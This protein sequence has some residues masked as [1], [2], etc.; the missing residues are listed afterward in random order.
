MCVEEGGD[1]AAGGVAG[2]EQGGG[3]A[4]GVLVEEGA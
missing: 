3:A 1:G 4:G 2:Y